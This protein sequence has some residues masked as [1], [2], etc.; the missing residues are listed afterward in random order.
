MVPQ[1]QRSHKSD[2]D[3]TAKDRVFTNGTCLDLGCGDGVGSA[4]FVPHFMKVVT[5]DLS[6]EMI[7]QAKARHQEQQRDP[8]RGLSS[9]E[10]DIALFVQPAE[11][12]LFLEILSYQPSHLS[13]SHVWYSLQHVDARGKTISSNTALFS[14]RTGEVLEYFKKTNIKNNSVAELD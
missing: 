5:I 2:C 8:G 3:A 12:V 11:A 14:Q 6:K 10:S 4:A 7:A 1:Q 13:T 9:T